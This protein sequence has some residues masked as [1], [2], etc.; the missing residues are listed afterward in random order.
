MGFVTLHQATASLRCK[1][2]PPQIMKGVNMAGWKL[3]SFDLLE[4][5]SHVYHMSEIWAAAGLKYK[6]V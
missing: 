6:E 5:L 3:S 1:M 2:N 4:R